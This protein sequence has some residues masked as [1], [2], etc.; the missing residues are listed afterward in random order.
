LRRVVDIEKTELPDRFAE[1]IK[2][3]ALFTGKQ[4][5]VLV[6]EYDNRLLI[7]F[8]TMKRWMPIK[9]YSMTFIKS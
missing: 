5:V 9:I 7:I 1:L 8:R 6:D 3:I 2:K 4:V